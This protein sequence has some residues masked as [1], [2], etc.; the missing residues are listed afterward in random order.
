MPGGKGLS[1]GCASSGAIDM[2]PRSQATG[3]EPASSIDTHCHN[4]QPCKAMC[5]IM[6][7]GMYD[8]CVKPEVRR[9][10]DIWKLNVHW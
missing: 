4:C 2:A 3:T 10:D 1:R 8:L 7:R 6:S 5:A 9:A